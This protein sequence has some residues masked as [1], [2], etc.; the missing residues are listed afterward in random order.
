LAGEEWTGLSWLRMGAGDGLLWIWW[1]T[2]GFWRQGFIKLASKGKRNGLCFTNFISFWRNNFDLE[3]EASFFPSV[4][5]CECCD[6]SL[7]PGEDFS[8]THISYSVTVYEERVRYG[9][10]VSY[11]HTYLS[12]LRNLQ[13]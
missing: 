11:S 9:S 8:S 10:A 7:Q 4:L 1:W 2:C 13:K 5:P 3:R 6:S 12:L